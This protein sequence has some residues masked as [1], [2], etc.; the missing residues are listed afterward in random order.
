MQN[1]FFGRNINKNYTYCL[2]GTLER[3]D[4]MKD[5]VVIFDNEL[6]VV[7]HC[8]EKINT[9][10]SYLGIIKRNF[11]YLDENAFVMLYKIPFRICK[12]SMESA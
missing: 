5:L 11:I 1:S 12:F 2:Q 8:K 3:L 10:Y 9:A 7:Q 6:N 4:H